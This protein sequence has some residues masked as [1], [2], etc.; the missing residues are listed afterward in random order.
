M[1]ETIW[2]AHSGY[3]GMVT[4]K[5]FKDIVNAAA[6]F[7]YDF[8]LLPDK[9][10]QKLLG[11]VRQGFT[12][13]ESGLTTDLLQLLASAHQLGNAPPIPRLSYVG[14]KQLT[15]Y[16]LDGRAKEIANELVAYGQMIDCEYKQAL[17][18][19]ARRVHI[20]S[21][22][23][24]VD[25][26]GKSARERKAAHLQTQFPGIMPLVRK[27]CQETVEERAELIDFLVTV[28]TVTMRFVHKVGEK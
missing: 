25:T 26:R 27:W 24:P 20:S 22:H 19:S 4:L 28:P 1:A 10:F 15:I 13:E 9:D 16:T 3:T 12:T 21:Y 14:K 5:N 18:V 2:L 11:V 6:E 17:Q 23:M 8:K 7:R